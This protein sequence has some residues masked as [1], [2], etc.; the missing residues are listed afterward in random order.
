MVL[1]SGDRGG[2][3][4]AEPPRDTNAWIAPAASL[5][6]SGACQRSTAT[7]SQSTPASWPGAKTSAAQATAGSGEIAAASS[8]GRAAVASSAT[9]IAFRATGGSNTKKKSLSAGLESAGI[10]TRP[11]PRSLPRSRAM[12]WSFSSA[13]GPA[14]STATSERAPSISNWTGTV[15]RPSPPSC[16]A[17]LSETNSS[18]PSAVFW[19]RAPVTRTERFRDAAWG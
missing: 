3:K 6:G 1:A 12:R 5:S 10:D 13:S 18:A 17:S 9:T 15:S 14:R 4:I 2:K 19:R 16:R 11:Q 7:W 8:S